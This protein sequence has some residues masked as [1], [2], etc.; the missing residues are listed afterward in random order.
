MSELTAW[1]ILGVFG[2]FVVIP[3]IADI[4]GDGHCTYAESIIY[5]VAT[6]LFFCA[7]LAGG[8]FVVAALV[9]VLPL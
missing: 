1:I 4:F 3:S 7:V 6:I 8:G 5:G 9:T 2:V